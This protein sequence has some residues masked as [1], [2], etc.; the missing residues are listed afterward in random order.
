MG[1]QGVHR[2]VALFVALAIGLA[3]PSA[4]FAKGSAAAAQ[5]STSATATAP[6]S[7]GAAAAA[8]PN[9]PLSAFPQPQVS[10]AARMTR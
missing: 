7:V 3:G 5:S 1:R 6:A 8:N 9:N 2:G 4:A 10:T